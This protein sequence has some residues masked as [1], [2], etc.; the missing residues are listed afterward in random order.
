MIKNFKRIFLAG[1][2]GMV[3]SSILNEVKNKYPN[4]EIILAEKCDLD[5]RNQK[6]NFK[7]FNSQEFRCSNNCS[8]KG[9]RYLCK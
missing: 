5:L 7:F 1:H 4:I 9:W 6:K 8:S 3:G 2:N